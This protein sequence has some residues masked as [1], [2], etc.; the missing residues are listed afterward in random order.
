MPTNYHYSP[1][2][3]RWV[4]PGLI[5]FTGICFQHSYFMCPV[6]ATAPDALFLGRPA[7]I[8]SQ[9]LTRC[10][11]PRQFHFCHAMTTAATCWILAFTASLARAISNVASFKSPTK[12]LEPYLSGWDGLATSHYN[13]CPL[14][15]IASHRDSAGTYI[16]TS[17][18]NCSLPA[19]DYNV[20]HRQANTWSIVRRFSIAFIY[21][22]WAVIYEGNDDIVRFDV[23][24]FSWEMIDRWPPDI[25]IE[26]DYSHY[27]DFFTFMPVSSLLPVSPHGDFTAMACTISLI[28]TRIAPPEQKMYLRTFDKGRHQCYAYV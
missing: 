26:L 19:T 17:P 10:W 8:A 4:K 28:H 11:P 14:L 18:F 25:A 1:N 22:Y 6:E 12:A 13:F 9:L 7:F 27:G 15:G 16:A 3:H 20:S 21:D 5:S 24:A 2:G 23:T